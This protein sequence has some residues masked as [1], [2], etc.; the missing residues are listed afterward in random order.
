MTATTVLLVIIAISAGLMPAFIASQKGRSF[1]RW[2][3]YGALVFPIAMPHAFLLGGVRLGG[4]YRSCGFCRTKVKITS[5]NCP[6]CGHE[7]VDL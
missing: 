7:F 2:W 6:R 4:G 1:I 3:I 5:P